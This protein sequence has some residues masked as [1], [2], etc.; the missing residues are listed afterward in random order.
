MASPRA[1]EEDEPAKHAIS[2]DVW[3]GRPYQRWTTDERGPVSEAYEGLSTGRIVVRWAKQANGWII[4]RNPPPSLGLPR[5]WAEIRPDKGT[6]IAT[7]PPTWHYH[8]D[9]NKAPSPEELKAK[10]ARRYSPQW[11]KKSGHQGRDKYED[12]HRGI[13]SDELHSHQNLAKYVFPPSPRVDKPWTHDHDGTKTPEKRAEHV[14]T[15]HHHGVEVTGKHQHTSRVKDLTSNLA[16]RIDMHP[17]AIK[18]FDVDKQRR[19]F[20]AIEGCLKADAILSQGEAVLSVPSVTLWNCPELSAVIAHYLRGRL[21]VIV[22]DSDWSDI[23]MVVTQARLLQTR[24]RRESVHA[25]I[26][27]PPPGRRLANGNLEKVGVD[28]FLHDGGR[29]DDLEVIDR[30]PSPHLKQFA[31]N[32][33]GRPERGQRAYDVLWALSMHAD[34]EG[35]YRGSVRL[36]ARIMNLEAKRGRLDVVRD[37]NDIKRARARLVKRLQNGMRDLKELGAIDYDNL[38]IQQGR[39]GLDWEERKAAAIIIRQDLR[40]IDESRRTLGLQPSLKTYSKQMSHI[41]DDT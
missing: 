5:V 27:A 24:L 33:P 8:G 17:D 6:P 23:G 12:D 37:P 11:A 21:V 18:K 20:F 7:A 39:F 22:P 40:A 32:V 36:L 9:P 41:G 29:L 1:K 26:A 14:A 15:R 16:A 2:D 19:A 3:S 34:M 30:L 10:H 35:W 28:D 38:E 31:E 13:N 25:Q 4:H